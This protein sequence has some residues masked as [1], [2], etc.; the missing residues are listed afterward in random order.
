VEQ[1]ARLWVRPRQVRRAHTRETGRTPG[2][3]AHGMPD[4]ADNPPFSFLTPNLTPNALDCD[5][6][7]GP[8]L[9]R[10]VDGAFEVRDTGEANQ[11]FACHSSYQH[12]SRAQDIVRRIL[13]CE[14]RA[15]LDRVYVG[16]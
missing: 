16:R 13:S 4:R 1:A 2:A 8:G 15:A 10:H 9:A 3:D 12:E 7:G 6:A 5:A 14:V 11:C